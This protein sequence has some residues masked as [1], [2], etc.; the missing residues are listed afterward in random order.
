MK[1][2]HSHARSAA[3]F[4]APSF[5]QS[6]PPD[7]FDPRCEYEVPRFVD[8]ADPDATDL[9]YEQENCNVP[10]ADAFFQ[11]FQ[12]AHD[13][14]VSRKAAP[15]EQPLSSLPPKT[16]QQTRAQKAPAGVR[17]QSSG[18]GQQEKPQAM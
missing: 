7:V 12:A 6:T 8:L 10:I 15:K 3:S 18:A 11:W 13:F 5:S 4:P 17:V 2:T 9:R 14:K 1:K 16:P